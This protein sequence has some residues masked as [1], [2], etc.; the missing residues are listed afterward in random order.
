MPCF[1]APSGYGVHGSATAASV[2]DGGAILSWEGWH[3]M[4][5]VAENESAAR[6]GARGA[7]R[8]TVDSLKA[9]F[10]NPSLR[11][12]QLALAGSMIGD[13]AYA[14]AV[15]VWAYGVGGAQAVG[16]WTAIRLTLMALGSPVG[17]TIADR[18]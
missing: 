6:G 11:R 16:I 8:E 12:I 17:A 9:V 13:W 18:M 4:T 14:T 5:D 15:A 3:S 2:A 1:C 7:V 10:A